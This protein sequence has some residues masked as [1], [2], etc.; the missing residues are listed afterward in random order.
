MSTARGRV[1][2]LLDAHPRSVPTTLLDAQRCYASLAPLA[3]LT[4]GTNNSDRIAALVTL[5]LDVFLAHW[6]APPQLVNLDRFLDDVRGLLEHDL[7]RLRDTLLWAPAALP[8]QRAPR[9]GV[10]SLDTA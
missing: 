8:E 4:R 6:T 3:D 2:R 9:L 1:I 5:R 10:A 7:P